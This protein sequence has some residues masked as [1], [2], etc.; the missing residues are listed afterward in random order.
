MNAGV[1]EAT[2][3]KERLHGFVQGEFSLGANLDPNN[4]AYYPTSHDI[5]NH[6]VRCNLHVYCI[7]F[8]YS[9]HVPISVA[10]S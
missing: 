9:L 3:I 6:M 7:A 2:E 5:R 10:A 8:M 4:R 1:E